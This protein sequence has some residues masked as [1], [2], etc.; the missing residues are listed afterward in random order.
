[1]FVLLPIELA[2]RASRPTPPVANSLLIAV[3]VLLFALGGFWCVGPGCG[4]SGLLLYGFS[5]FS[6]WHLG[7]L[8]SC[9]T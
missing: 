1:M 6:V 4:V 3:N 8:M 2:E 9:K 5:H 7:A